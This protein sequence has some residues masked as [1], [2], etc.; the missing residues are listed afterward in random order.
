MD[1]VPSIVFGRHR[2]SIEC[3]G[4][5]VPTISE[6]TLERPNIY[7]QSSDEPFFDDDSTMEASRA[8]RVHL[9][10]KDVFG[11]Q[12]NPGVHPS[13]PEASGQMLRNWERGIG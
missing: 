6:S 2:G 9:E 8:D 11:P 1:R 4:F 10:D 12:S 5:P 13:K 3:L 7:D